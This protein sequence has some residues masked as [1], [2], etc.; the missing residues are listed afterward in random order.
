MFPHFLRRSLPFLIC[1]AMCTNPFPFRIFIF[2]ITYYTFNRVSNHCY[3][4]TCCFGN[5]FPL[6]R[7]LLDCNSFVLEPL[8]APFSSTCLSKSPRFRSRDCVSRPSHRGRISLTILPIHVP[9]PGLSALLLPGAAPERLLQQHRHRR[10]QLRN[11]NALRSS[12][13]TRIRTIS[14]AR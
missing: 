8:H 10:G 13:R 7:A 2:H 12:T 9:L 14:L 11:P 1:V 5:I 3:A 4:R 6:L